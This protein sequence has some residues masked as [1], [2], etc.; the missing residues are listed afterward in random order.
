MTYI[1]KS[2]AKESNKIDNTLCVLYWGSTRSST[3]NC[4][5]L[6]FF[7]LNKSVHL[8]QRKLRHNSIT[9]KNCIDNPAVG[10]PQQKESVLTRGKIANKDSA[11]YDAC[12]WLLLLLLFNSDKIKRKFFI[13]FIGHKVESKVKSSVFFYFCSTSL[14]HSMRTV[15]GAEETI[16][17]W[18]RMNSHAKRRFQLKQN[19]N[20]CT[21]GI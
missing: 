2:S 6:F 17:I 14:S 12:M 20:M 4:E 13:F 19:T 10:R 15:N 16:T 11:L 21:I 18:K 5:T 9:Y 8:K 3:T 7:S 1:S